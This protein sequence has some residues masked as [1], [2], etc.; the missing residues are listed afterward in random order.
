MNSKEYFKRVDKAFNY[1]YENN[2]EQE[3]TPEKKDE[4]LACFFA[5]I[6]FYKKLI[7]KT[8]G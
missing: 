6:E 2:T 5:G 3:H 1:W 7:M 4:L 8:I